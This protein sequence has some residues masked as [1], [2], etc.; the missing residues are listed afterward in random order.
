V[1]CAFLKHQLN[2]TLERVR[3]LTLTNS[4]P[5]LDL[6]AAV[7]AHMGGSLVR[8]VVHGRDVWSHHALQG[9]SVL[10]HLT[11]LRS[12]QVSSSRPSL[13][14][15][16]SYCFWESLAGCRALTS[17]N[18]DESAQPQLAFLSR[19]T[20]LSQLSLSCSDAPSSSLQSL[21]HLTQLTSLVCR[22]VSDMRQLCASI[23]T[24]TQ[25]RELDLHSCDPLCGPHAPSPTS[26]QLPS[27]PSL[28]RLTLRCGLLE[29]RLPPSVR[30]LRLTFW[31]ENRVGLC[32]AALLGLTPSQAP[33]LQCITL[34]L[35][36][37]TSSCLPLPIL[38]SC[39]AVDNVAGQHPPAWLTA[40]EQSV[41]SYQ[42]C[43]SLCLHCHGGAIPGDAISAALGVLRRSWLPGGQATP[44]V[45]ELVLKGLSCSRDLLAQLPVGLTHLH[46]EFCS[47]QLD[48][49][50]SLARSLPRLRVLGLDA[51]I[52]VESL[53][54]LL[55]SAQ[56][57]GA[58]TVHVWVHAAGGAQQLSAKDVADM[59][60]LAAATRAPQPTP[61]A[62]W[63][64]L[65]SDRSATYATGT[66]E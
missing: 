30:E 14:A 37:V 18:L 39:K 56:Q 59:S 29:L 48:C 55:L 41:G 50:L 36:D 43:S 7:L 16:A 8:L 53:V 21:G 28:N 34:P 66:I 33:S 62:V 20:G 26:L 51:T 44:P 31:S 9:W 13:A 12:M 42:L 15:H 40:L 57:R 10:P 46:L 49:V 22:D 4:P 45:M 5:S 52:R 32:P 11:N 54:Q 35:K 6:V 47:L 25:L 1:R 60:G 23:A 3:E 64:K 65:G 63:H 2:N 19:L 24:L 61:R 58:L 17:L 27:L 38:L